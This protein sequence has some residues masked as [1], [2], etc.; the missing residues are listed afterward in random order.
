M[1]KLQL[2]IPIVPNSKTQNDHDV[3][4]RP[5]AGMSPGYGV[6]IN[7]KRGPLKEKQFLIK[8]SLHYMDVI[9]LGGVS[10][11]RQNFRIWAG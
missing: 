6:G 10:G 5:E 8:I 1:E 7:S 11:W 9:F 4:N 2:S 3:H